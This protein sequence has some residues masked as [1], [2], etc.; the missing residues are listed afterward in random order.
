MIPLLV[1]AGAA[2]FTESVAVA[3]GAAVATAVFA[4]NSSEEKPPETRKR[5]ISANQVPDDI[6][7]EIEARER[8]R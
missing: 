5:Q 7:R 1:A 2:I 4:S 3:T 8:R 6:R